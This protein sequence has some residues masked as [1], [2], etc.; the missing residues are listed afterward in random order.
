MPQAYMHSKI[1]SAIARSTQ[2]SSYQGLCCRLCTHFLDLPP[3]DYRSLPALNIQ[4]HGPSPHV[5]TFASTALRTTVLPSRLCNKVA[6]LQPYLSAYSC[7]SWASGT[8]QPLRYSTAV[9]IRYESRRD[10]RC[11][12]ITYSNRVD[13]N[14]SHDRTTVVVA[15]LT[16]Y[17]YGRLR[18]PVERRGFPFIVSLLYTYLSYTYI[19]AVRSSNHPSLSFVLPSHAFRT[20]NGETAGY[21][22]MPENVRRPV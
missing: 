14:V 9:S 20:K 5:V 22:C 4:V 21:C 2:Y 1:Y 17:R 3:V 10:L 12:I 16:S 18:Q 7:S 19:T 11:R 6:V 13:A 15:R 8:M